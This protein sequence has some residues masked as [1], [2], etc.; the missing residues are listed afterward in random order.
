MPATTIHYG[1]TAHDQER[2]AQAVAQAA[3]MGALLGEPI[4]GLPPVVLPHGASLHYQ[5]TVRLGSDDT[6]STVD[7][8]MRVWGCDNVYVGSNG[9]IPTPAACNPTLT[10]VA[11]AVLGARNLAAR[12]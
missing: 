10:N 3:Q 11:L 7:P 5:G 6:T 1:F 2:L 4:N 12:F 8:T 9:V